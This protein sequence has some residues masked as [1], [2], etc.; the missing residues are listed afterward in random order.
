MKAESTANSSKEPDNSKLEIFLT[1]E[2]KVNVELITRESLA[3]LPDIL[4]LLCSSNMNSG[5]SHYQNHIVPLLLANAFPR[6]SCAPARC[7]RLRPVREKLE[8]SSAIDMLKLIERFKSN[9]TGFEAF[10]NEFM[11]CLTFS[12]KAKKTNSKLKIINTEIVEKTEILHYLKDLSAVCR[13]ACKSFVD[14]SPGLEDYGKFWE[15]YSRVIIELELCFAPLATALRTVTNKLLEG[16]ECRFSICWLIKAIFV[17]NCYRP[18]EDK[19]R[20]TFRGKLKTLLRRAA[21][22]KIVETAKFVAADN[23]LLLKEWTKG[24][25]APARVRSEIQAMHKCLQGLIDV[26][27]NELNVHYI[28]TA[29]YLSR[30]S[31]PRRLQ[32]IKNQITECFIEVNKEVSELGYDLLDELLSLY[33]MLVPVSFLGDVNAHAKKIKIQ[34]IEQAIRE[35]CKEKEEDSTDDV[36]LYEEVKDLVS[37]VLVELGEEPK[38]TTMKRVVAA[39]ERKRPEVL[40]EFEMLDQ[41]ESLMALADSSIVA[42][43]EEMGLVLDPATDKLYAVL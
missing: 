13:E 21:Y 31:N 30:L 6:V 24:E 39:V 14:A 33:K 18:L 22:S 35:V 15:E 34:K 20:V 17:K 26:D 2:G 12:D 36:E 19:L 43:N 9:P 25:L 5:H 29:S 28:N 41:Y 27:V 3:N 40:G 1:T 37:A 32:E 7:E 8:K 38:E 10:Y 42:R 11:K 4:F 16:V 23:L